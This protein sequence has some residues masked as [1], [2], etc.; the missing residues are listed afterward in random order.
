MEVKFIARRIVTLDSLF[1]SLNTEWV[2]NLMA[3]KKPI[4]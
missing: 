1:L 3:I 2:E 4:S